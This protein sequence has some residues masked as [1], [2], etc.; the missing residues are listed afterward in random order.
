M[1]TVY[2][3]AQPI[4]NAD[5]QVYG[6]E[7]LFRNSARNRAVVTDNMKATSKMLYTAL[8]AFGLKSSLD[9]KKAFINVDLEFLKSPLCTMI[10]PEQ[11]VYEILENSTMD[12]DAVETVS[13][14]RAKGY[15]F[16]IDDFDLSE[17]HFQRFKPIFPY[18]DI[19]KVDLLNVRDFSIIKK[20]LA[21]LQAYDV[22]LV[23]EKIDN[24][25]IYAYCKYLGF[26]Y[27]QGYFL[28]EPEVQRA[29]KIVGDKGFCIDLIN[30]VL[31]GKD[32]EYIAERMKRHPRMS[33]GFLK[34]LHSPFFGF[35]QKISSIVHGIRMIGVKRMS[36][37]LLLS[38]H[39]AESKEWLSERF[40]KLA[41]R[42]SEMMWECSEL[43]GLSRDDRE[44][45]HLIG[46]VSLLDIVLHMPFEK[47]FEEISFCDTIK[48]PILNHEGIFGLM[49][50]VIRIVEQGK[51]I[52]LRPL[53]N[54]LDISEEELAY[55][56]A[57]HM[58]EASR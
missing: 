57:R 54:R 30:H 23:A 8:H 34:F 33:A 56:I 4:Y 20:H 2:L 55:R 49:L 28:S 10:P 19:V 35:Q 45:A 27:F 16:A 36:S 40:S 58:G 51:Q 24:V 13:D 42:R 21:K 48:K 29:E 52:R 37:W 6:Y 46:V 38:L 11:V 7:L 17:A 15:C 53:M 18:V 1:T 14:L 3:G 22:H 50:R 9:N 12:E 31:D 47:I 43:I 32:A 26:H 44:T 39:N 5:Q 25:D 41:I